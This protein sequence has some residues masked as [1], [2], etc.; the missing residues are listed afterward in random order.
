MR[1]QSVRL[2][3]LHPAW[4]TIAA[5]GGLTATVLAEATDGPWGFLAILS[6]AIQLLWVHGVYRMA[7][8]RLPADQPASPRDKSWV[9]LTAAIS[10]VVSAILASAIPGPERGNPF[11]QIATALAV[12]AYFGSIWLA[13]VA[14]LTAEGKKPNWSE[15]RLFG[16]FL[17]M[18]Y[19]FAGAWILRARIQAVASQKTAPVA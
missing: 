1:S 17:M 19:A 6:A 7:R 15:A 3:L 14:L 8:E 5:L 16:V 11:E 10:L 13:A 4:L 9:F 18:V 12:L 2:A